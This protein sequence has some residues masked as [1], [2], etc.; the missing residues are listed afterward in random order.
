MGFLAN[1]IKAGKGNGGCLKVVVPTALRITE[2]D[3]IL[4][5]LRLKNEVGVVAKI[6][7]VVREAGLNIVNITTPSI[8]KGDYGDLFILVEKC[9]KNCGEE[10]SKKIRKELGK[11]V[12][13][14]NVYDSRYNFLFIPNSIIEFMG[15]ESIIIPKPLVEE[16]LK[17][18]YG[19]HP[20][21]STLSLLRNLGVALGLGLYKKILGELHEEKSIEQH[22]DNALKFFEEVYASMGLGSPKVT[23][24]NGVVF[25]IEITG[26]LESV[27]LKSL[28]ATRTLPEMTMGLIQGYLSGLT[29]R[30][31]EIHVLET[32]TRG[33][34]RDLFEARVYEYSR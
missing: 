5:Y 3:K 1:I 19:K 14:I 24:K 20:D 33:S 10:L 28:E 4:L 9:D 17:Q 6:T 29:G 15:L 27:I 34:Q 2:E 18:I 26:N 25:N 31:V 12:N 11:I 13:D 8:V 32:L 23:Y 30:R 22:Y 21:A 16:A 7:E